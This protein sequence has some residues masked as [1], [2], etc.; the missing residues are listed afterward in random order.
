MSVTMPDDFKD[1]VTHYEVNQKRAAAL[2]AFKPSQAPPQLS[3]TS[4][5]YAQKHEEDVANL[6]R[7]E[8]REKERQRQRHEQKRRERNEGIF[9][10]SMK[11]VAERARDAASSKFEAAC[12]EKKQSGPTESAR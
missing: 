2:P 11:A 4:R 6:A 10:S 5:R 1:S 7:N 3:P 8:E 9:D 12:R